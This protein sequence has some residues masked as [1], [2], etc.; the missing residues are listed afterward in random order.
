MNSICMMFDQLGWETT[1]YGVQD[2]NVF[3]KLKDKYR[4][5]KSTTLFLGDG[6]KKRSRFELNHVPFALDYLNHKYSYD[7]LKTKFSFNAYQQIYDGYTITYS[8]IQLA[9]YMGFKQ[10]Y[11]LGNDFS[12]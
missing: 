5:L 1:Y 3:N 6:I 4:R 9:V 8:L 7:K 2:Y 10:I 11:L 12:Y